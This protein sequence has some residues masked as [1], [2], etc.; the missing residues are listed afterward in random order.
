MKYNDEFISVTMQ[1]MSHV[2]DQL[3]DSEETTDKVEKMLDVFDPQLRKEILIAT[4]RGHS[5]GIVRFRRD[6]GVSAAKI[7]AIKAVRGISGLGLREAK[8]LVE[9]SDLQTV[10]V[11]GAYSTT[12]AMTFRNEMKSF[13]YIP[14]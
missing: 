2:V 8:D 5:N 9:L 1:F 12:Q 6:H 14:V 11:P 4:I 7:N 3:G 10:L 13:G